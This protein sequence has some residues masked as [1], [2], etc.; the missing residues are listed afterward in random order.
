MKVEFANKPAAPPRKVKAKDLK[1]GVP[2]THSF[3]GGHDL[4]SWLE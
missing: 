2:F 3:G 1:P 4:I